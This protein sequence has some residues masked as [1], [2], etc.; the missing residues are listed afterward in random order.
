MFLAAGMVT[1]AGIAMYEKYPEGSG[2]KNLG[3]F[4]GCVGVLMIL[5]VIGL[6]A[7]EL[8]VTLFLVGADLGVFD[9]KFEK[10]GISEKKLIEYSIKSKPVIDDDDPLGIKRRK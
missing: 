10:M 9:E 4:V 7:F 5:G 2:M 8:Y 6:L 3:L 1:Y